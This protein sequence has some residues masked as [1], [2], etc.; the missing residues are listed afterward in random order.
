MGKVDKAQSKISV[1]ERKTRNHEPDEAQSLTEQGAAGGAT[2]ADFCQI[3]AIIQ[4]SLSSIDGKIDS[5]VYRVD[6]MVERLDKHTE[7]I[8]MAE[9]C[10]TEVEEAHLE[11]DNAKTDEKGLNAAS[12]QSRR[13]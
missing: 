1:K 11:S 9:R 4:D 3:L 10:N 7:R 8:D 5:L 12:R 6:R 2:P 13:P